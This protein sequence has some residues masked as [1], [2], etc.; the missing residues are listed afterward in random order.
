MY[1]DI[2]HTKIALT[3]IPPILMLA[4]ISLEVGGII[5]ESEPSYHTNNVYRDQ[6]VDVNN[7]F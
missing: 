4:H 6:K 5:I 3:V 2:T 7:A 1:I